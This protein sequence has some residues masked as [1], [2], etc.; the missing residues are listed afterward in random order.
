[1]KS[2]TRY[3]DLL[4]M[5][6]AGRLGSAER[7]EVEAH[8]TGCA[9]CRADL[10]MWSSVAVEV[11][12]SSRAAAAP[13]DLASRAL[14]QIHASSPQPVRGGLGRA[15]R[16]AWQLL[17]AQVFLVQRE[18]WP[19]SAVVIFLG[20]AMTMLSKHVEAIYFVT[21]MVAAAS[22]AALFGPTNDPAHELIMST[23]TSPWRVVLARLS[24]V[25][26]YNMLL[27]LAATLGLMTIMPADL[28]GSVILGWLG[29][30]A[31]LS[32]LALL[33]SIWLG[34]GN[35][36]TIT[37]GLWIFH[38]IP[39]QSI[40]QLGG[41]PIWE[42]VLLAYQSI[43]NHSVLLVSLSILLTLAALWSSGRPFFKLN[44]EMG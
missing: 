27:A 34:T 19:A 44:K 25:S 17:R 4:P 13:P 5:Y 2:H 8:L 23:P 33:L 21:P 32:A 6:A 40:T 14:A 28:L 10:E 43:W 36:V 31:F 38:Y 42:Q 15:W 37:Y 29:P 20:A 1:M 24:V 16:S 9:A 35:A 11:R 18:L 7:A 41:S 30:M 26:V 39:Y 3:E 12:L 22:L